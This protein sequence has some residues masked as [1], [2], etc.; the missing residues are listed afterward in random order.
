MDAVDWTSETQTFEAF[1]ERVPT[2]KLMMLWG[3]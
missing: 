3:Q 2:L 1:D